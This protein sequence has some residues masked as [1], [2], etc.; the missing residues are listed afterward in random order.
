[1]NIWL[2]IFACGIVTFLTRFLPLTGL[3]PK[4]LPILFEKAM[5]YVPICVLTSLVIHAIF[6]RPGEGI[7]LIDNHR[8]PAALIAVG[9]AFFYSNV[10][11]TII[12]GLA[13]L[14]ILSIIVPS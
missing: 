8:I 1:M 4:K 7:M 2:L 3:T 12:V 11:T 5:H 9:I 6:V 13:S 14:W 10:A